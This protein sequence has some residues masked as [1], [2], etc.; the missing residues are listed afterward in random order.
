[1]VVL[2]VLMVMPIVVPVI[3]AL[4]MRVA[5]QHAYDDQVHD[6]PREGH[7]EH[8]RALTSGGAIRWRIAP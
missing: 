4:P 5:T 3:V 1:M 7:D 2:G 6:D 8:R